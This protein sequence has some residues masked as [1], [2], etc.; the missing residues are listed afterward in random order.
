MGDRR[1][2][3]RATI[4]SLPVAFGCGIV[5]LF[6]R[7]PRT[8]LVGGGGAGVRRH[9]VAFL[10][11]RRA[12]IFRRAGLGR[13][14]RRICH[15]TLR[16]AAHRA[17]GARR[18]Q[19]RAYD[20]PVSSKSARSARAATASWCAC[21]AS[22]AAASARR[23]IACAWRCAKTRR[24]RSAVSSSSRR[25]CRRRSRRYGP[26]ATTSRAKLFPAHR[27]FRL[28]TRQDQNRG[29]AVSSRALVALCGRSSTACARPS[30]SAS[31]Y[32]QIRARFPGDRAVPS[33]A[34]LVSKTVPDR[35]P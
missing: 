1:G 23:P 2:R 14:R 15:A 31:G 26:A 27:R 17:S 19:C 30:T 4:A 28:C 18:R 7:R 12:T 32:H 16:T 5:D 3:A 25:I 21:T 13:H 8:G 9:R 33:P 29:A 24:R 35:A 34:G 6:H 11:R 20:Q 22:K 10:A